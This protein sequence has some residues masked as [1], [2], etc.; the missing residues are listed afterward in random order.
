MNLALRYTLPHALYTPL[1]TDQTPIYSAP[2][3]TL[4][5]RRIRSTALCAP[6]HVCTD[7]EGEFEV[8]EELGFHT[9]VGLGPPRAEDK[10][11]NANLEHSIGFR[12]QR[13]K[14]H[15]VTPSA[16]PRVE[17]RWRAPHSA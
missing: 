8:V 5:S 13:I 7:D 14:G 11:K 2:P 1:H 10:S 15:F 9:E 4:A 17:K 3:T 16:Q 6:H 12:M